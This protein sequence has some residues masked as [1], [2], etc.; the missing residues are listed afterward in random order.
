MSVRFR[1]NTL[2]ILTITIIVSL[3]LYVLKITTDIDTELGEIEKIDKFEENVTRLN[4]LMEYFIASRDKKYTNS[5]LTLLD[6]LDRAK[7]NIAGFDRFNLMRQSIP[8][9]ENA[10]QLILRIEDNPDFYSSDQD[11]LQIQ[12]RALVLIRSDLRQ[13]MSLA[14]KTSRLRQENIRSLQVEQRKFILAT[15]IPFIL[16]FVVLAYRTQY[17]ILSSLS[18]L[19]MGAKNLALGNLNERIKIEG[20]DEFSELATQFNTMAVKLEETIEKERIM[21]QHF[22]G[23]ARELE[24]SNQELEQFAILVSN[25]LQEPLRM[26]NSFMSLLEKKYSNSLDDKGRMYIRYAIDGARRMKQTI[27]DLLA[28]SKVGNYEGEKSLVDLNHLVDEVCAMQTRKITEKQGAVTLDKLP[29]VMTYH[30]PLFQVFQHLLANSIQYS[31]ENEPLQVHVGYEDLPNFHKFKVTDNGIGIDPIYHEK[32]FVIFQR[33]DAESNNKGTGIGL[34]I[35]KKIVNY[36]GG[37]ISIDS[38]PEHGTTFI[39]TIKKDL[40]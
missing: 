23:K 37:E 12:E 15:T 11:R 17:Q 40:N 3:Y 29:R 33:L 8:S 20:K 10:L 13:L 21:N 7:D 6:D 26:V 9:V 19:R 25:D 18:K 1:L 27:L 36:L 34:A 14:F 28:Y 16:L 22:E 39:F 35:V 5:L 32:V 4:L 30:L 2:V 31:R 24:L 38:K